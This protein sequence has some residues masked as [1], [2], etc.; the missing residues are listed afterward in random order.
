MRLLRYPLAL[1]GAVVVAF[2][3]QLALTFFVVLL[4]V[5]GVAAGV[6]S[7]SLQVLDNDCLAW[8]LVVALETIVVFGGILA[9]CVIAPPGERALVCVATALLGLMLS[10]LPL[11]PMKHH[12]S[13]H[14]WPEVMANNPQLYAFAVGGL[15]A[16][17][18]FVRK[19]RVS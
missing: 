13:A 16:V 10:L 9:A 7:F 15:G 11:V 14:G 19:S 4:D 12:F 5:S 2:G 1:V 18:Y 3:L 8:A 17:V 6:E